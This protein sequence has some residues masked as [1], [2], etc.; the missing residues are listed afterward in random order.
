LW[1]FPTEALSKLVDR[2]VTNF[3]DVEMSA[4][5]M[6]EDVQLAVLGRGKVHF[7]GRTGGMVP[8][9]REVL[10]EIQKVLGGEAK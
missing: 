1:P 9:P 10:D 3:L 8:T 5:Q 2:G 7:Y 4:G 6:V